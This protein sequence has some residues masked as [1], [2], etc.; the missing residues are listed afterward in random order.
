[1]IV[2]LYFCK[3]LAFLI[4]GNKLLS[5]KKLLEASTNVKAALY[6]YATNI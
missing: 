3:Y 2:T 4:A 5:A 1:M 6:T